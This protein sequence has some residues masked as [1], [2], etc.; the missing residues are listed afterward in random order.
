[1]HRALGARGEGLIM[2]NKQLIDTLDIAILTA[3]ANVHTSTIAKVTAVSEKTID[4]QPVIN[5]IV[6]GESI[7]L[8]V[9]S[10][11]PPVFM[12][13]GGSYTAHPI[14][15]GDYCLLILTERCFDGWYGGKDNQ[16]PAELRMHDYSDGLAIVG[17][18]PFSAAITIPQVIEQMGDG[19]QKGNWEQIGDYI[20]EG[21]RTQTGDHTITGNVTINGSLTVNA[22]AGDT[23]VVNGVTLEV[24]DGDVIV[25]G[26]SSKT[27]THPGDS[28]GTTGEPNA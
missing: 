4:V 25:D 16:A 28:G 20:H 23:V 7:A 18:N 1:M 15:V 27:H 12:Q 17:V 13:G 9:F 5:R 10:K 19:Y 21:T 3:L 6:K 14:T 11:V 24:V 8:P 2:E 22:G 26:I